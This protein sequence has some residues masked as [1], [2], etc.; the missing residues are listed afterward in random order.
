MFRVIVAGFITVCSCSFLLFG[1]PAFSGPQR[2]FIL[3]GSGSMTNVYYS[4]GGGV[5]KFAVL[6]Y[7]EA[8]T[9][10]RQLVCSTSTTAGSVYNLNSIRRGAMDIGV[11]QSDIG[12]RAY[13]GDDIH[14]DIPPMSNLRLLASMHREYLTIVVRRDSGINAIDDIKGKRINIGAPGTGVR[15]AVLNLF[16]VKKWTTGDFLV[17]SD[18]RS[19]EQV[20]ALCDGKIDVITDFVG[21]PNAGMQEA[22]ATCDAVTIP[23]DS[24]LIAALVEK[25]PYYDAGV[26]PG[27]MYKNNSED[28]STISVRASMY[29]T[30]ALSDD[31][32]YTVVKSIASNIDRF[33]ELSGALAGFKVEDLLTGESTVPL[34]D[35]ATRFYKEVG[36]LK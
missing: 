25:Y 29:A 33:R 8:D 19:S 21:H 3:I 12:Y 18:L 35:G 28:V 30:T 10:G 20:Q 17:A 32:A 34:H 2:S 24:S 23:L 6:G 5:C 31:I 27:H 13:V 16:K 7:S 15:A 4:I 11:A 22:S 1:R 14:S 26:I 36:M 9:S